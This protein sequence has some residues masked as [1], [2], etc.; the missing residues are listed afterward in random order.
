[1]GW[2]LAFPQCWV[3][4]SKNQLI[5]NDFKQLRQLK[6]QY[7]ENNQYDETDLFAQEFHKQNDKKN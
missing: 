1:M 3:F 6:N 4:K 2:K 7:D 5:S